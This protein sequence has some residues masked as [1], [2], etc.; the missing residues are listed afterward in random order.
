MS[1]NNNSAD[2]LHRPIDNNNSIYPPF[3][4]W[5]GIPYAT[6]KRFR[7][8]TL[9]PFDPNQPYDK[10]GPASIQAGDTSWL[11]SDNGTSEDCLNLN[12]WAPAEANE[13]LP[14][15]VY[16][17]GGGF[18]YGANTQITSNLSGLASTGQVVGVSINYR[19]GVLGWLSLSQYGG[20]FE[21]ATNLGLQDVI[22]ALQWVKQNIVCFGGDPENV[23][24][25]G[26]S[27]GAFISAALLAAPSADGL[28]HR[29]AV[30]SGGASRIVPAWWAEELAHKVLT[31]LGFQNDPEQL[32]TVD[33]QLLA[34]TL[35]KVSLR[36]IGDKNGVDNNTIG[37]V[38]DHTFP[39]SVIS[40][41]PLAV[42]KSGRHRDID[43]L[44]SSATNEA[45]WWVINATKS[46]DPGSVDNIVDQLVM[47]S[48]IPRS[49]AKR[50][51]DVYNVDGRT[52]VEVRGALL[53]DYIYT[54]PASRAAI[55]HAAAGGNAYLLRIGPSEGAPA[56]HGT[57]MYGI[58][59]Q[60]VPGGSADQL[61]RDTLVRDTLI[62]LATGKTNQLWQSVGMEPTT[63]GIG[64]IPYDSTVYSNEVLSTF[65]GIDRT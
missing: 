36:D 45:D 12:I 64:R 51:V 65:E 6:A 7:K 44:F 54:L 52:P 23:T 41:T 20:V 5:L 42:L 43:I 40:E 4:S 3:R 58:V 16:I 15:V 50:I 17:H 48:R 53:T 21:D 49:R 46:F 62:S 25:T 14:V 1:F 63:K 19:L 9:V 47:K 28:Y 34:E 30:F 39:G 38:N 60:Q 10:K 33:A 56:V 55:S 18:E 2:G 57:E 11:D 27:A 22:T 24:V 8:P 61:T 59:G 37:I 32:L 31:E 13:P 35:I 29:L 26:H